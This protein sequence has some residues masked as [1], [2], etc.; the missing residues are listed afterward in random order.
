MPLS[1]ASTRG[2]YS[3]IVGVTDGPAQLL[4]YLVEALEEVVSGIGPMAEEEARVLSSAALTHVFSRLYLRDPNACLDELL[5]PVADEHC[6]AATAAVKG[7]VE[8]LLKEFHD[9]VLVPLTGDAADPAAGGAG[10]D[11]VTR[12]GAPS[13]GDGGVQG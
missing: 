2:R 6:A 13:A 9:F 8:A 12:G 5:E 1:R 4:P 3:R 10:E 7:Q 11:V